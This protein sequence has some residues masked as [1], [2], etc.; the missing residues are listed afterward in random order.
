MYKV[1]FTG[2]MP[3]EDLIKL[4]ELGCEIY[5][6][7]SRTIQQG[8]TDESDYDFLVFKAKPLPEV[9]EDLGYNLEK[10]SAH[11]EP[12]EG[13]FNSWRKGSVN[14]ILTKDNLFKLKFLL[15]NNTAKALR[16]VKREERVRLFQKVL[17]G[18]EHLD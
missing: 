3:S 4:Q 2:K 15:A 9:M 6:V 10:G 5:C 18:V 13:Q 17:Y 12:S 8:F 14:I 11:Y 7:G 16:L 1:D